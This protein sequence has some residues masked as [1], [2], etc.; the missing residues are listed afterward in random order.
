MLKVFLI[1]ISA[2]EENQRDEIPKNIDEYGARRKKEKFIPEFEIR[3]RVEV[4]VN[5]SASQKILQDV[6]KSGKI[7]GKVFTYDVSESSDLP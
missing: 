5:D 6:K 1:S 4:V 3:K 2:D 7:H